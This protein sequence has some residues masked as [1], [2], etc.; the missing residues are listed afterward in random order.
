MVHIA[1]MPVETVFA[2]YLVGAHWAGKLR[3]NSA[4][5]ALM[6]DEG[7][8]PRVASATSRTHIWFILDKGSCSRIA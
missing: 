7:T 5:V 4:F 3:L 1:D 6:L 2:F 8:A